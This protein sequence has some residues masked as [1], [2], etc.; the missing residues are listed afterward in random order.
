MRNDSKR[1]VRTTLA[2]CGLAL[3]MAAASVQT[4]R[5]GSPVAGAFGEAK[6]LLDTRLRY[7]YVDQVATPALR[8]AE[9][10]TFR[11]RLGFETG[12]AWSTSLLVEGEAVAPLYH[13]HY[14]EDNAV[15]T[16]TNYPVVADPEDQ[17]LNRLQ[18]TNTALT[19][20]TITAGR[21]RII[22]DDQ[23]FVGNVGWRQNEQTFDALRVVNKHVANL[24][25]DAGY[26]VH[27]NRV[28]GPD[29]PQSP[30]GGDSYF[31]NVAYQTRLGKLTG[32]GYL[33]G[34]HPLRNVPAALDPARQATS[35][36]GARF[37]GDRSL[38][39][40][41]V[42]YAASY[43]KQRERGANPFRNDNHYSLLE[44]NATW[45][46]F[47]L[48][49]GDEVLSGYLVPGTSTTVGFS[50][51]LATL[52]K[53]QGWADKFLTT[54]GNGIDDRYVNF[55]WTKKGLAGFD[56]LAAALAWHS[57]RAQ[58]ISGDYGSE[59]DFSLTAK[60]QRITYLAKLA[61]YRAAASTPTTVARDT[62][63]MWLQMEYAY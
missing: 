22:L 32:F 63:K 29:S 25:V 48:G 27:V 7:E 43:A 30:W 54:P 38:G 45:K 39:V 42:A 19:D 59:L 21:Q 14:R 2:A 36:W 35:T 6:P 52:H 11:I 60:R 61:D 26:I 41:K 34:F 33:L 18:L 53:F 58:R 1:V 62:D 49:A 9:A 23:R 50:T 8:K 55:G 3:G 44:L 10:W 20:T 31:A 12:K 40:V 13:P 46:Q 37:A 51:P 28:Y 15:A 56:T 24:T 16:R 17:E 4:A 47:T 5:A 57:Y